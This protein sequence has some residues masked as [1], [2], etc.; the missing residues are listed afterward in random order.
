M[1]TPV[2]ALSTDGAAI[3]AQVKESVARLEPG[4]AM[5]REVRLPTL[6]VTIVASIECPANATASSL[7]V[8][9]S[10]THQYYGPKAL[11]AAESL[12]AVFKV[13]AHQL[14]PVVI[15]EF[16]IKGTPEDNRSV[17]LHGVATA[18]LSMR[19]SDEDDSSSMHF[20]SV[21]VPVRLY[22]LPDGEPEASAADR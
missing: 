13:P 1:L 2:A 19:C 7:V 15:P 3:T 5:R 11:A 14:A 16:C 10:D 4:D 12:E 6:D 21:Q 22:C 20:T 8:S 9:V 18:Q 17:E